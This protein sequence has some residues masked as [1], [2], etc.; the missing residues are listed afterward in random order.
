M[1]ISIF[2]G[3]CICLLVAC[4]SSPSGEAD[5]QASHKQKI[6]EPALKAEFEGLFLIG[7]ALSENQIMGREKGALNVAANHF[8]AVTAENSMKWEELQPVEGQFRWDVTDTLVEYCKENDGFLIGHTLVWHQQAPSWVFENADGSPASRELLLARMETHIN[9]VVG[10]YKGVIPA[11]D[12]VNEAL[13]EDGTM[14]DSKWRTII[15][16]DY[17]EK[18]FEYAHKADP[19][20]ELYYNDF[21]LFKPEKRDGAVALVK[22]VQSQGIPVHG[23][24]M[25]GHY[26]VG[27]PNDLKQIEDAIVA[28]AA[29]GSVMVTELDISVLPFP[30]A[31]NEGAD[32]SLNMELKEK[33]N[34]YTAGLPKDIEAGFVSHYENIFSIYLDHADKITR[35]T[36]WGL[37]DAQSWRNDW[38]MQ[39]RTD[40][41]LVLD[42]SNQLK[43]VAHSLIGMAKAKAK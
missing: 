27:Y 34:P 9:T 14:R 7:T 17:I 20:A 4:G 1:R 39:G 12:V 26:G 8:N 40:Y 3:L 18:A 31:G 22:R 28:F 6:S 11:W 35:V 36:F 29:L 23:I 16:D 15:G 38:P 19:D 42:R 32:I 33:Y 41:P 30:D 43:P 21:N 10:R 2:W 37:N 13:N 24:G 5:K 25:Q